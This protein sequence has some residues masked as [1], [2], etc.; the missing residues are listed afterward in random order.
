[1][2]GTLAGLLTA[3]LVGCLLAVWLHVAAVA[4]LGFCAATCFAVRYARREAL[5][6]IVVSIP[7][8]FG[9]A[10]VLAQLATAPAGPNHDRLMP[11]L[12][13][14][15]LALAGTA[16]WLFVGTFAGVAIAMCRGLPRCIRQL[17]SDLSG[18]RP[19]R[20]PPARNWA[21]RLARL[22]DGPLAQFPRQPEGHPLWHG[23]DLFYSA[24]PEF[25]QPA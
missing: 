16:P 14:T 15:L 9:V 7:V 1:M 13:G 3:C 25:G 2:I 21:G 17:R 11:V 23:F 22:T 8:V 19:S 10:E 6:G 24:E 4:G 12:E 5:L 20:R 18:R